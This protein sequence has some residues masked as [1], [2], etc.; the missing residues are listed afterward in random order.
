MC[1][2]TR[3]LNFILVLIWKCLKNSCE[4]KSL[5]MHADIAAI[6]YSSFR[7]NTFKEALRKAVA[8]TLFFSSPDVIILYMHIKHR[9]HLI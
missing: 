9:Q 4:Q 1:S 3:S 6:A 8:Q 2:P 7:L 5:H